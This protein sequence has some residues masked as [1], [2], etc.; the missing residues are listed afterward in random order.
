MPRIRRWRT[1]KLYRSER[2]Q[3]YSH[4]DALFSGTVNWSLIRE[5]YALFMQ[6]SIAIQGGA[7]APSAVLARINSY[8][9]Q[10]LRISPTRIGQ[11]RAH[12]VFAR[13]DYR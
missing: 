6:L 3:Y 11:G 12:D 7:L 9:T 4:I 10:P 5:H 1:L 2:S 13:L 8:S